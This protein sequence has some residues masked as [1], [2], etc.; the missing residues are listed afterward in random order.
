MTASSW[1]PRLQG[2]VAAAAGAVLLHAQPAAAGLSTTLVQKLET[3]LNNGDG[4]ALA[5][6]VNGSDGLVRTPMESRYALL[7]ERFP[8]SRWQLSTGKDLPDGR[9]TLEVQVRGSSSNAEGRNFRL[10]ASQTLAVRSEGEQLGPQ[11]VLAEESIVH[12]GERDLPV[13]VVVPDTVLTGQRYDL[14]VVMDEPLKQAVL[15]GGLAELT[16]QQ[17]ENNEGP[18]LKLG[19]L[20]AG[21][22]FK[23]IQAP[24]RPGSQSWAV[25]LLHPEGTV[26]ISRM[27]RVV[28]R[29]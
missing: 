1:L 6:L 4:S 21:G 2:L 15:A 10:S 12:S 7:R 13:S 22:I 11:E 24:Y 27:V 20:N 25:L 23:T 14:D 16:P 29:L 5:V 3:A 17:L 26:S 9:S 28:D 18:D 8:D 19:A